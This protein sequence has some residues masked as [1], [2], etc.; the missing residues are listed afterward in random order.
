MQHND[1]DSSLFI[2]RCEFAHRLT[3]PNCRF[4]LQL[5]E[6]IAATGIEKIRASVMEK[7]NAKKL[8]GKQKERM[9]PKMGKIDIDY[10]VSS[11][12]APPV[13]QTLPPYTSAPLANSN[14]DA[15]CG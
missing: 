5:P 7:E 8:K 11:H 3:C 2:A 6:F 4:G 10:Q 13:M 12:F 15:S 9:Q 1:S 14:A